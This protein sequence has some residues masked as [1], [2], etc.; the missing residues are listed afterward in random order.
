[1]RYKL[2]DGEI[3]EA[4]EDLT[5]EERAWLQQQGGKPVISKLADVGKAGL[6]GLVEGAIRAPFI[7]GDLGALG[8][9]LV[10][11]VRPGTFSPGAEE[12]QSNQVMRAISDL[13]GNIAHMRGKPFSSAEPLSTYVPETQAGRYANSAG[14]AVGGLVLGGT[15][16]FKNAAGL[17]ASQGAIETV[18]ALAK[19]LAT[20]PVTQAAGVGAAGEFAGDVSRGFDETA[21]QNPLARFAGSASAA[22]AMALGSFLNKRT[23][24]R[25]LHEVFKDTD[26]PTFNQARAETNRLAAAGTTQNTIGDSFANSNPQVGAMEREVS[27]E[28]GGGELARKLTGRVSGD[29][30]TLE[31]R[32]NAAINNAVVPNAAPN[33]GRFPTAQEDLLQQ[34][35]GARTQAVRSAEEASGLVPTQDVG[36]I[37]R[38]LRQRAQTPGN[39]RTLDADFANQT[40]RTLAGG[41]RYPMPQGAAPAAPGPM[42]GF[43]Q[44][45]P[46]GPQ[47]GATPAAVGGVPAVG[48]PLALPGPGSRAVAPT[49]APQ[50]GALGPVLHDPAEFGMG[51]KPMPPFRPMGG[52]DI[53]TIEQPAPRTPQGFNLVELSKRINAM[54]TAAPKG[55]AAAD[56]A[57]VLD[58]NVAVARGQA[59]SLARNELAARNPHYARGQ[60]TYQDMSPGVDALK[61]L[62]EHPTVLQASTS[63]RPNPVREGLISHLS[64]IDP[65]LAASTS[66]RMRA[67]DIL[68]RNTA[69]HGK[70]GLQ[71]ELGQTGAA[72]AASPWYAAYKALNTSGRRSANED[73][74]RLLANPTN[75]NLAIL[76]NLAR[77]NPDLARS[78]VRQ[79]LIG[80]T[81]ATTQTTGSQP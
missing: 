5:P 49:A 20:N 61:T 2:A 63:M 24:A 76:E 10:N 14:N 32:S 18:K 44:V 37:I 42:S 68:S 30:P 71:N 58:K 72:S 26:A 59:L 25:P 77:N 16:A 73:I 21:E 34:A 23:A 51:P 50:S 80:S 40:A 60:Q 56:N 75:E 15:G 41:Y 74:S 19:K 7:G 70:Q 22:A 36:Q 35:R 6:S 38:A 43:T 33:S 46:L 4:P 78:L 29:I 65:N 52:P 55:A 11:K 67:A 27:N 54:N 53:T 64:K 3:V 8:A 1:M 47:A 39:R 28:M 66:E 9:T 81:S 31:A 79:G 62:V 12:S 45:T 17:K 13:P 57:S 69:Q 48:G